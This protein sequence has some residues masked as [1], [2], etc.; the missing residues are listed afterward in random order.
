MDDATIFPLTSIFELHTILPVTSRLQP[1]KSTSPLINVTF[2]EISVLINNGEPDATPRFIE[3]P[4]A[5]E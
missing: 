1:L 2:H 3:P 5:L 4:T